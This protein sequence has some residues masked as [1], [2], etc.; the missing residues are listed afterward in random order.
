M[1]GLLKDAKTAVRLFGE[2]R[3]AR[4][5]GGELEIRRSIPCINLGPAFYDTIEGCL[6]THYGKDIHDIALNFFGRLPYEEQ[7]WLS[8]VP[9]DGEF[10]ER[11]RFWQKSLKPIMTSRQYG[12]AIRAIIHWYIHIKQMSMEDRGEPVCQ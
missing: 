6:L 9:K 3:R 4:K 5:D 7:R 12:V 10:M 1:N 2:M 8:F 11:V